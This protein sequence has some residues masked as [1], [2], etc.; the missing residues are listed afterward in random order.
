MSEKLLNTYDPI[1]V[2]VTLYGIDVTL[3][4][5]DVTLYGSGELLNRVKR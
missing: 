5:V 2:D 3:Y 4:G 1:G